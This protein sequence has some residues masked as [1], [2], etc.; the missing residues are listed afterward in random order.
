MQKNQTKANEPILRITQDHTNEMFKIC[1]NLELLIFTGPGA[2][3]I[4]STH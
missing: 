4:F 2:Y 1:I 3:S